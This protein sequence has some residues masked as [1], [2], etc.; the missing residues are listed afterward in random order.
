MHPYKATHFENGKSILRF[1]AFM[2]CAYEFAHILCRNVSTA[3]FL[4]NVQK[5]R[6]RVDN[7]QT[8]FRF[9]LMCASTENA[10]KKKEE[11][12]ILRICSMQQSSSATAP[13]GGGLS[14]NEIGQRQKTYLF[15]Q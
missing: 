1:I 11:F 7:V 12:C 2:V 8:R 14:L 3:P 4:H 5:L 9:L 6:D 13:Y 15:G 10:A